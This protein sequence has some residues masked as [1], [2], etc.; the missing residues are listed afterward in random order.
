MKTCN[1]CKLQKLFT[2]FHTKTASKDG[3]QAKCKQCFKETNLIW[4]RKNK[5]KRLQTSKEWYDN[6]KN[7]KKET[8]KQWTE[9]NLEKYLAGCR[10]RRNR[11]RC[12]ELNAEGY[13][14]VK[15]VKR[16]YEMQRCKCAGCGV[17]LKK[18]HVDHIIPLALGGTN[19]ANNLQILCVGCN[20]SKHAKHPIDWANE[21]GKLL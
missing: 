6:N 2:E 21:N 1:K 13:F 4:Y 17:K 15:D 11:R 7:R 19:W 8:Q 3:Y 5:E 12:R 20:L 14:S 16:I 18:Y 10:V 9:K